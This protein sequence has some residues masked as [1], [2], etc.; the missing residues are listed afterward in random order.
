MPEG[1]GQVY[2]RTMQPLFHGDEEEAAQ[3]LSAVVVAGMR[4][5]AAS[6]G[7][8]TGRDNAQHRI[9]AR[10]AEL[11]HFISIKATEQSGI[12]PLKD[13]LNR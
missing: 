2:D 10:C 11:V 5:Y 9:F 1:D 12:D 6:L 4:H 13:D 3:H 8:M 7:G